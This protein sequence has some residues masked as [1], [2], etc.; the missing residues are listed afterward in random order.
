MHEIPRALFAPR[1]VSASCLVFAYGSNLDPRQMERRVPR[2]SPVGVAELRHFTLEFVGE[3]RSWGGGV[4][5]VVP[6]LSDVVP[7]DD[8]PVVPGLVWRLPIGGLELL[9]GYEGFPH[10]YGR[11]LRQLAVGSS[12]VLAWVY[13]HTNPL[14]NPASRAYLD[15]IRDGAA[16]F[17]VSARHLK[18]AQRRA[19]E[20][21]GLLAT[22]DAEPT[23]GA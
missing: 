9:D 4:A 23:D 10:V 20:L 21:R 12:S 16:Q 1:R 14:H 11:E 15:A 2:A 7:G 8:V 5:T 18:P 17:R 3:S 6:V 19:K 22:N 13:A